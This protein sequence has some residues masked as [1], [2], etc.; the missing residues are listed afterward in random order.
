MKLWVLNFENCEYK[1]G[2]LNILNI[3]WKLQ[4]LNIGNVNMRKYNK[5]LEKEMCQRWI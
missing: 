4:Y 1:S 3:M 5:N 2:I